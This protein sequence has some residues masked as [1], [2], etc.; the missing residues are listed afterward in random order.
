MP[1]PPRAAQLTS[2][3]LAWTT[4]VGFSG[5]RKARFALRQPVVESTFSNK[6]FVCDCVL[7][8]TRQHKKR[9]AALASEESKARE[10][11][12]KKRSQQKK[13]YISYLKKNLKGNKGLSAKSRGNGGESL[14]CLCIVITNDLVVSK[15]FRCTCDGGC[16]SEVWSDRTS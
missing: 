13:E 4:S 14:L 3:S 11:A 15:Y 2:K 7:H 12:L 8:F 9:A 5:R 10:D 6:C 1:I 16:I